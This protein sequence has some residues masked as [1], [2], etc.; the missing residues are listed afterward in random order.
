ML[1]F[2]TLLPSFISSSFPSFPS[3]TNFSTSP[4]FFCFLSSTVTLLPS[5]F[6]PHHLRLSLSFHYTPSFITL[7][8]LW[9]LST[10]LVPSFF[11]AFLFS[12]PCRHL[13]SRY[14]FPNSSFPQLASVSLDHPF[15]PIK[16][17]L[18]SSS[19]ETKLGQKKYHPQLFLSR[20]LD[21]PF[22]FPRPA[23]SYLSR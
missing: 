3:L 14:N 21:F 15:Y 16:P 19:R 2:C 17:N 20:R 5:H 13:S 4:L 12:F 6:I 11:S 10:S 8:H 7:F 22:L 9:F 18:T 1:L 23:F